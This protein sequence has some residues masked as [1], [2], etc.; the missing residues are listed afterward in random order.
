MDI[1]NIRIIE[2]GQ[3][4]Q[5][6]KERFI[7]AAIDITKQFP[8]LSISSKGGL[9]IQKSINYSVWVAKKH[10]DS[11]KLTKIGKR[12]VMVFTG[13]FDLKKCL[14]GFQEFHIEKCKLHIESWQRHLFFWENGYKTKSDL[15][16]F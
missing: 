9:R 11:Y 14:D 7:I 15:M 1:K 6:E 4:H 10:F 2:A 5:K 3:K 13:E 8:G 12:H 16:V